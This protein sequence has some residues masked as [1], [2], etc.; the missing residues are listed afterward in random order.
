MVKTMKA[1]VTMGK[2]TINGEEQVMTL[3]V[4]NGR[5]VTKV[6]MSMEDFAQLLTGRAEVE[7]EVV[8]PKRVL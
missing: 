8:L 7:A 4:K 2:T 6:R 5:T 1:L 3:V